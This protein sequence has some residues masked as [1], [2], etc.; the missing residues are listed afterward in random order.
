MTLKA[1]RRAMTLTVALVSAAVLGLTVAAQVPAQGTAQAGT[2]QG[3]GRGG[4]AQ[5]G[6]GPARDTQQQQAQ[7]A[8]GTGVISG[9]VTSGGGTGARVRRARITLSGAELRGGRSTVTNDQGQF[10]FTAL[11]AGR[12]TLTASK[13]GYVGDPF[14]V[15]RPSGFIGFRSSGDPSH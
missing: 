9:V 2:Q 4:G 11:P 8:T 1:N 5:R 10:T 3:Q 13:A 15:R 7:P 14:T 6:Q 12:Y